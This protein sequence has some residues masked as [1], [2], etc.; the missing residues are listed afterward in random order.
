MFE[1]F[2][3][4]FQLVQESFRVLKKDKEIILFPILSGIVTFLLFISFIIPIFLTS[5]FEGGNYLSYVLVFL[6]YLLSYFIVIFFNT[7]LITCAN[8]RLNG[9]DP[10]F[11]DG[12]NNALRHINKI[13]VWA[14]ISATVG[15]ILGAISRRSGVLGRIV[16]GLIGMV[17]SLLTFF[18]IPVMIFENIF[19]IESIKKS[20][21]LLRKTW[22]ENVVGQFSIGLIFGILGLIGLVFPVLG[23]LSGSLTL[24]I[25]SFGVMILYWV[26]LGIMSS[27]LNGIFTVA[28]YNFATRGVVLEGFSE[29]T[30]RNAWKQKV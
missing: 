30:L 6:Y 29:D 11:M 3:R 13:L 17:W 8:I 21:A 25:I 1:I 9:G 19:V 20:G 2:G 24:V 14:L 15:L 7:G 4:S 26:F 12:I 28:L 10:K 27:S 23:F 18:V 16:V 5:G 22:G